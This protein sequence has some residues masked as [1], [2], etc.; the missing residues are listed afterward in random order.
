VIH[1]VAQGAVTFGAVAPAAPAIVPTGDAVPV[2]AAALS[3]DVTVAGSVRLDGTLV[4]GG[5]DPI[6]QITSTGGDILV[7]GTLSGGDAGGGTRGLTLLA[8]NGTV[9]VNG[10]IDSSGTNAGQNGGAITIAAKRVV[11]LGGIS[12]VGADG[13]RGGSGGTVTIAA[14]ELAFLGGPVQ[15]HGGAGTMFGGAG[16]ALI[17]DGTGALQAAQLVD[18]RGGVGL[19]DGATAGPPGAIRVGEQTRP[20]AVN[21]SV[22][23]SARGGKGSVAGGKGG[24]IT[25][26]PQVGNLVLA[27]SVDFGGGDS[28]AQ[29]G[30]GGTLVGQ[31]GA[32]AGDRAVSG[33]DIMITGRIIGSGGAVTA[34]GVGNGGVA[35]ALTMQPLSTLGALFVDATALVM[36]DGGASG[37][38]GIAGGGGHLY[39]ITS[40]GDLTVAGMLTLRGGDARDPGGTGGLG[41]AVDIFS[42]ADFDGLGGKLLLDTTAVIDAS[43]GAGTIG[44]S[45]RNDGGGGVASFPD[46]MEQ[47]AVLINCDGKHGTTENWLENRGLI[48]ARG[49]AA[50]GNGGDIAY[51]GI[52]PDRDS[53]PPSG[54]I[55]NAGDGTGLTGDF[56]GE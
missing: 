37:G 17:V 56:A 41:G 21:A 26:E 11:I 40:S 7:N 2:D 14:T 12:A 16:G 8:P 19:A 43:G 3:A 53:S 52:S 54:N 39:F 15:V 48:R 1:V 44:G 32:G 49:G 29:P 6:R 33:G 4:A 42:D 50:N 31:A 47:I 46:D 45:A 10:T 30:D 38:A 51:H 35:G 28:A 36:L 9:Y 5:V 20:S 25:L 27:S 13:A 18:A 24:A 23:L 55:D 22:V 34:G